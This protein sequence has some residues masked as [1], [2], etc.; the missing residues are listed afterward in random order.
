MIAM[1]ALAMPSRFARTIRSVVVLAA[2]VA[3]VVVVVVVVTVVPCIC[4]LCFIGRWF[5]RRA[6]GRQVELHRLLARFGIVG[7]GIVDLTYTIWYVVSREV[8]H[9]GRLRP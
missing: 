5:A 2:S 1:M 6:A 9:V 3:A 8:W 4:R 7:F